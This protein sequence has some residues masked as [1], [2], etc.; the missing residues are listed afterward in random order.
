MI[1]FI[2]VKDSSLPR[3]HS[4]LAAYSPFGLPSRIKRLA[5]GSG[6][7]DSTSKKLLPGRAELA[8][9]GIISGWQKSRRVE[10]AALNPIPKK[11]G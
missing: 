2:H 8:A 9:A 5:S 7:L 10:A 11:S 1:A 6:L 4:N 3:W